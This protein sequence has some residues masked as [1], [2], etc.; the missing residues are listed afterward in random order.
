MLFYQIGQ[1]LLNC[2][3]LFQKY[4]D[5]TDF[6]IILLIVDLFFL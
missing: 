2:E 5:S 1:I 6:I 4:F 3:S